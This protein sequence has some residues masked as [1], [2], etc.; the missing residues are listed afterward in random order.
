MSNPFAAAIAAV[1]EASPIAMTNQPPIP[2]RVLLADGDALCYTCAGNDSTDQGQARVNLM[3]RMR[4][5]KA[6]SRSEDSRV[7][8]T[9]RGS[10]KGHRYAIATVKA[11]QGQRTSS[12]RPKN[13]EYL[14][15]IVEG[16]VPNHPTEV[17]AVA[18]ADDL[19]AKY[20]HDLGPANVVHHTQDKDMRMIP[21]WHLTWDDFLLTFV[22]DGEWEHK[23]NDKVY[24]RK[25][26]WLQ[27][28]H[29]DG[30]DNIPGLPQYADGSTYTDKARRGMLKFML[31]GEVTAGKL[32]AQCRNEAEARA[33]VISLY[34]TFYGADT[35]AA[36]L[37]QG[38]LLWMRQR[39]G[40]VFDVCNEGNPLCG[41]DA[42][43]QTLLQRIAEAQACLPS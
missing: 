43:R 27:M 38:V 37:E 26:F 14:R 30:A 34:Q 15:G 24:G 22:K 1:A 42:G 5:A 28:L 20:S 19:F 32:L 8:V 6:N 12:R 3:D 2:G 17:T 35:A 39:P 23:F 11:Y 36:V 9:G 4:R 40:D 41:Y 10:H 29:G 21:G 33:E 13:W 25:W 18:E 16:G 31:C 7:L